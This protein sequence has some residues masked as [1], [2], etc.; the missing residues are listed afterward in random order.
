[1]NQRRRWIYEKIRVVLLCTHEYKCTKRKKNACYKYTRNECARWV[2]IPHHRISFGPKT[3]QQPQPQQY[4]QQNTCSN[5]ATMLARMLW[6]CEFSYT[7]KHFN[8][9]RIYVESALNVMFVSFGSDEML[10]VCLYMWHCVAWFESNVKRG[11]HVTKRFFPM[12]TRS[13]QQ[14]V[15]VV[16]IYC[17]LT[18]CRVDS[19]F[20]VKKNMCLSA[21]THTNGVGFV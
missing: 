8:E 13:A 1:M 21:S 11:K 20:S 4:Q 9:I 2:L 5:L 18:Y 7:C 17:W 12:S 14:I 16:H 15:Y 10:S 19:V 3:I 6:W